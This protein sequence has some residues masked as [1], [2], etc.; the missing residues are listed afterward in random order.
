MWRA[1]VG[2]C[3]SVFAAGEAI[4]VDRQLERPH[5]NLLFEWG[6]NLK[7]REASR[8]VPDDVSV[9]VFWTW[10]SD[11]RVAGL[12]SCAAVQTV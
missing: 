1:L 8:S 7:L 12:A 9:S 2:E 5:W 11:V 6:P 10:S 3:Y 4:H